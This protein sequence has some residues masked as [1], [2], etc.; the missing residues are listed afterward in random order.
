MPRTAFDADVKSSTG[1]TAKAGTRPKQVTVV[2][3][4]GAWADASSWSKVI[5]LLLAK[6]MTVLAVQSPLTSLGDDVAATKRIIATAKGEVVLAGHSWGGTV[7]TEAGADPKVSALVYI[8]AFGNDAG[9]SGSELIGK[10][11]KPPAL[12]AVQMDG[13]GFVTSTVEGF[14]E[15]IAPDLPLEEA[16]TLAV[17]QGPLAVKTFDES[18]SVAAWKTKPSWFVVSAND[19]T[20]SPEL[21]AAVAERMKAKTTVLQSSHMSLLS[22]PAEVAGVIEEAVNFVEGQ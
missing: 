4:H 5:P 6:G 21:E 11:P 2:L 15:N 22:H 12:S 8:S 10:Y 16:R 17:T 9:E 14:I 1:T 19:R 7:I 20:I 3:V 13:A 18:P